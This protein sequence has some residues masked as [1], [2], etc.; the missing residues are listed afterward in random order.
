M[1]DARW[2]WECANESPSARALGEESRGY[3]KAFGR[4]RRRMGKR[5]ERSMIVSHV[6]ASESAGMSA[7]A[8]AV[9]DRFVGARA[10]TARARGDRGVRSGRE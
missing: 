10:R 5:N 9:G 6:G 8:R 4:W 1:R 3:Q 7:R 2:T